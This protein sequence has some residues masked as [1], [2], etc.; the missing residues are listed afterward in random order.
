MS[1]DRPNTLLFLCYG[2]GTHVDETLFSLLTL[3][4]FP[5]SAFEGIAIRI[6]TDQVDLFEQYGFETVQVTPSTIDEWMGPVRFLHRCK[7]L[8]LKLVLEQF[9]G[10]CIHVDGDTHF[11]K[12]PASLF[13]RIGP[14]RSVMYRYEGTLAR[15]RHD[16]NHRL[17]EILEDRRPGCHPVVELAHGAETMQWNAGVVGLDESHIPLLDEVIDFV[18]YLRERTFAPVLE[19]LTF[20]IVLAAKTKLM[21]ARDVIFHYCTAHGRQAFRARLPGLLA[22]SASMPPEE[23]ARWLY[24]RRLR[25]SLA[26]NARNQL[27]EVLHITGIYPG[28][29]RGDCC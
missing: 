15:S 27:K 9:G 14:N 22:E 28:R 24:A 19:Q 8:S 7:I 20:S 6:V 26:V 3:R 11:L 18:D 1:G 4:R 12:P 16:F 5:P 23:R 2:T 17:A 10:K 21:P 29:D 25:P 13:R